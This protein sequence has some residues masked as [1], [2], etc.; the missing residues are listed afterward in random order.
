MSTFREESLP[1]THE[2]LSAKDWKH[3]LLEK[4]TGQFSVV[5]CCCYKSY[6]YLRCTA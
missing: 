2:T 3:Q 4:A 6:I 5:L 1:R